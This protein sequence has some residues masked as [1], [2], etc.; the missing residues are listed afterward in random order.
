MRRVVEDG[1]DAEAR[2]DTAFASLLSGLAL[3]NAGLGAVHG[4]AAPVGGRFGVPHGV[5]CAALLPGV[6]AVNLA[7]VRARAPGDQAERR[8]TGLGRVLTGRATATADDA[9]RWLRHLVDDL[10]VPRLTTFGLTP[11]DLPDVA[12]AALGTSSMRGNPVSLTRD[13]VVTAA[14]LAL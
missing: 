11:E 8:F 3:A 6:M 12:D 2:E 14:G 13:E 5:A 9:V 4:L 7:A 1:R 10:P